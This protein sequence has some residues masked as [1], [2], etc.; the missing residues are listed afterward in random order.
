MRLWR[1]PDRAYSPTLASG[2]LYDRSNIFV[3]R[4]PLTSPDTKP[5]GYLF[6]RSTVLRATC[7]LVS[8]INAPI[9]HD[10]SSD[11]FLRSAL[12]TLPIR[13]R[14]V[15][16]SSF[17]WSVFCSCNHEISSIIWRS[18]VKLAHDGHASILF[19]AYEPQVS[20][21]DRYRAPRQIIVHH[22]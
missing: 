14:L 21:P 18:W 10:V 17:Q 13:E 4:H 5:I 19:P 7:A 3:P 8:T 11:G 2:I 6:R 22:W 20:R 1:H 15:S 9:L 16:C 12:G